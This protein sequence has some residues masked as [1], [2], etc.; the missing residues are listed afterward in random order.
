MLE[1]YLNTFNNLL[2]EGLFFEA[3][4]LLEPLWMKAKSE[5]RQLAS[6]L[7]GY[8]NA[9]IAFEHIK[10]GGQKGYQKAKKTFAC[11]QRYRHLTPLESHI[12]L[13]TTK[14]IDSIAMCM[15]IECN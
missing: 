4:E 6:L 1:S 3:H 8:I 11:Y 14:N 13:A 5:N 12:F 10:R 9:A 7:K 2:E 15:D